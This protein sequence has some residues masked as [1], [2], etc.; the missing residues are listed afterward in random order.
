[1]SL[2]S[3]RYAYFPY[4]SVVF[5]DE[6][7]F[8]LKMVTVECMIDGHGYMEDLSSHKFLLMSTFQQRKKQINKLS[9]YL[10]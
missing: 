9:W 2:R 8:D 10:Q 3:V 5:R 6:V 4:F 7:L 1:M